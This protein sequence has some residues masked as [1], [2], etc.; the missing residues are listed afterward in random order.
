MTD[1]AADPAHDAMKKQLFARL[2]KL[3]SELGDKVDLT[4]I[5]GEN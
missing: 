1:L 5:F 4:K 2:V 3:S